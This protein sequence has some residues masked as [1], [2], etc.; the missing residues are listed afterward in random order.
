MTG[1]S[2][3]H[4]ERRKW[5]K[6]WKVRDKTAIIYPEKPT[7]STDKILEFISSVARYKINP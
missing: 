5:C 4:K 1:H 6:N 3:G 2:Q 7:R